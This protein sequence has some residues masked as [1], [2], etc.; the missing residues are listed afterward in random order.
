MITRKKF[1]GF[2]EGISAKEY[3]E[4][5]KYTLQE[6]SDIFKLEGIHFTVEFLNK[7]FNQNKKIQNENENSKTKIG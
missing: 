7:I 6:I 4:P 5:E 3:H 2:T 1:P